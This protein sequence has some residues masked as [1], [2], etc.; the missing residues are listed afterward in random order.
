MLQRL[1]SYPS[2][3][4]HA[5]FIDGLKKM[6]ED[7]TSFDN[8]TQRLAAIKADVRRLLA[9]RLLQSNKII[10]ER[11]AVVG[12]RAK[13]K[14]ACMAAAVESMGNDK[15]VAAFGAQTGPK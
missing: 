12:R 3:A 5:N 7:N 8:L 9:D 10:E 15:A 6:E 1:P 14:R 4:S 11:K 13:N 2:E